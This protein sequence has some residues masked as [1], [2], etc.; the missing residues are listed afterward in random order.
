MSCSN[1][2]SIDEVSAT[3]V[4]EP[5]LL[6]SLELLWLLLFLLLRLSLAASRFCFFFLGFPRA[7][8]LFHLCSLALIN[9]R[10]RPAVTFGHRPDA[11]ASLNNRNTFKYNSACGAG[12]GLNDV[13]DAVVVDDDNLSMTSSSLLLLWLWLLPSANLISGN[14]LW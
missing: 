3:F 5:F 7:L 13:D 6:L 2:S 11:S 8:P 4:S 14:N 1:F 9:T 10:F 12:G